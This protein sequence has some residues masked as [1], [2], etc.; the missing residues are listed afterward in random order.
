MAKY[1][2]DDTLK[3]ELLG[4]G[5]ASSLPR[6]EDGA[7]DAA[8]AYVFT[9]LRHHKLVL[10][11]LSRSI[12]EGASAGRLAGRAR[13]SAAAP[14]CAVL[15]CLTSAR[16]TCGGAGSDLVARAGGEARHRPASVAVAVASA[17]AFLLL[18]LV[19]LP[20]CSCSCPCPCSCPRA[21]ARWA[22]GSRPRPR[23]ARSASW[24]PR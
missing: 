14:C 10:P 20:P 16:S 18:L 9:Q 13:R 11:A 21:R 6:R 7:A 5:K 23:R 4:L 3:L 8:T 12:G 15:R 1:Q 17:A 2:S 24:G 22:P 19:L